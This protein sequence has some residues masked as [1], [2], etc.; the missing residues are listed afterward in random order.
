MDELGK[1]LNSLLGSLLREYYEIYPRDEI[2]IPEYSFTDNMYEAY[3]KL[4]PDLSDI[5]TPKI[6]NAYNGLTV[7]PCKLTEKFTVL[8]NLKYMA[9]YLTEGNKTWIGTIIHETTH[10][11]DYTDYA[12]MEKLSDYTEIQDTNK[13]GMF[14]LWSEVNARAKG[15]YFV[16][17]HTFDDLY[18]SSLITNVVQYEL[19]AQNQLLHEKLSIARNDYERWYTVAQYLGRMLTLQQIFPNFFSNSYVKTTQP[20]SNNKWMFTWFLWHKDHCKLEDAVLE[21]EQMRK[22]LSWG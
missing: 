6:I 9:K 5:L 12:Q 19:P 16:R 4:R 3:L 2:I 13:H 20:F 8:I 18:D 7:I 14:N 22:I 11:L 17:K 1:T 15:Y 10:V 21:F